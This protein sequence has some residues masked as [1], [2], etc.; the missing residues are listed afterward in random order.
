MVAVGADCVDRL[1]DGHLD[2]ET[3]TAEEDDLERVQRQIRAKQCFAVLF[4]M[5]GQNEPDPDTDRVRDS[6]LQSVLENHGSLEWI[7]P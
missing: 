7:S 5:D 2:F 4:R 1:S 6:Q 3:H